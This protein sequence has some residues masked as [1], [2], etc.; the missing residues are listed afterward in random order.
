MK[1][2]RVEKTRDFTV[3]SNHHLRN[4]DL[5]L[6]AKGLMSFILSLPDEW[7][8]TL[9]GLEKLNLAGMTSIKSAVDELVAFGYLERVGRKRD[10]KGQFKNYE[11]VVYEQPKNLSEIEDAPPEPECEKPAYE[12]SKS[13]NPL[14]D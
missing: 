2:F 11:Y 1:C 13:E 9:S 4:K 8:L 7:D 5:S 10:A 12:N 3:M 14:L 6:K